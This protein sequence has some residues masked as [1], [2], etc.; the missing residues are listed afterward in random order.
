MYSLI[1]LDLF[2]CLMDSGVRDTK[3][4]AS[5]STGGCCARRLWG[6]LLTPFLGRAHDM[7]VPA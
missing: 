4:A 1:H 6:S 3:R 5:R 2:S 7:T